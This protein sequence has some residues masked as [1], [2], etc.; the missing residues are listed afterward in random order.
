LKN[1]DIAF[2]FKKF[3]RIV[4]AIIIKHN[5]LIIKFRIP[6]KES[7]QVPAAQF[8]SGLQECGYVQVSIRFKVRILVVVPL[9]YR[10]SQGKLK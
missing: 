8:V 10:L 7:R 5:N 4:I 2:F 6:F 9:G 3:G 1:Q